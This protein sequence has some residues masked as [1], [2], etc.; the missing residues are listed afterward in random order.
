M[1]TDLPL[2]M[3]AELRGE[4]LLPLLGIPADK[5]VRVETLELTFLQRRLDNVLYIRSPGG[6]V[7]AHIIEWLGYKDTEVLWRLSIY[8]SVLGLKLRNMTVVVTLVY[9]DSAYDVGNTLE[10][11][12]DGKVVS[13]CTIRCI[14]LWE[15]DAHEAMASGI[16][17]LMILCPLMHNATQE[18]VV[19][20]KDA[21]LR[22][23]EPA[24]QDTYLAILGVFAAKIVDPQ[25]FVDI[26]GRERMIGAEFI[27]YLL[28]EKTAD[29]KKQLAEQEEQ[30]AEQ[31]EQLA[32]FQAQLDAQKQSFDK[33]L[34]THKQQT[35][36]KIAQLRLGLEKVVRTRFPEI[37][38]EATLQAIRQINEFAHVQATIL[39]V[40]TTTDAEEC[41]HVLMQA[42]TVASS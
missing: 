19:E 8:Q 5:V 36:E 37:I 28:Q 27:E 15:K 40:A 22:E 32:E 21:I 18:M 2:K 14:R 31:E 39:A 33:E 42:T 6:Q 1:Q 16:L 11:K 17:G 25:W 41:K 3:L 20:I 26:I 24:Q 7:Y 30:L 34:Q 23:V 13:S 12:I 35:E 9:L 10:Q 38:D 29:M 4:D